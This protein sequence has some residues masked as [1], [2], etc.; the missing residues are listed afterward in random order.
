MEEPLLSVTCG[1][2]DLNLDESIQ[3][4]CWQATFLASFYR[5]PKSASI[6]T[7]GTVVSRLGDSAMSLTPSW[8][9]HGE[10]VL[11]RLLGVARS[12]VASITSTSY[13][14]P[15]PSL[16]RS[17][18]CL[19]PHLSIEI[20]NRPSRCVCTLDEIVWLE[21]GELYDMGK[22]DVYRARD[23]TL[24]LTT[25][26]VGA[27][28]ILRLDRLLRGY[29]EIITPA[30]LVE[31]LA[32]GVRHLESLRKRFPEL[33]SLFVRYETITRWRVGRDDSWP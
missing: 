13:P 29:P 6:D 21:S 28:D 25:Y 31:F 8:Y 16:V 14:I 26:E 1:E 20:T 18:L 10:L 24:E 30:Q 7:R 11:D 15:T 5:C 32:S 23:L 2:P 27:E 12:E 9:A 3:Q 4:A 19:A 33:E 17:K 22:C